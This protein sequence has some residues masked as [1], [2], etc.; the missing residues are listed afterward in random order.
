MPS[1]Q[2][3]TSRFMR[4]VV[5]VG[6][7]SVLLVVAEKP[8]SDWIVVEE[9]SKVTGLGKGTKSSGQLSETGM[10]DTLSALKG[11]FQLAQERGCTQI[12][13][14]AT[15]AARIAQNTLEFLERC[16]R[17][18]TPVQVMSGD[19]EAELGFL[20]V[21]N[22]QIFAGQ[23]LLTIIDVGGHSTEVVTASRSEN[24]WAPTFKKSFA[25]GALALRE[26]SLRLDAPPIQDILSAVSRIDD[27][28]SQRFLPSKC[29]LVVTLGATGTNL[30][31]I[32]DRIS[33]WD[34]AKVH[35]T[36]LG[37]EDVS[38]AVSSLSPLGDAGR[39]NVVGI[40][41]GR[42][43]TLH[44]GALILERCLFA[45]GANECTVSVRGWRHAML[46]DDSLWSRPS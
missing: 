34:P 8:G 2:V 10:S 21:A 13:A 15:M 33:E 1:Q 36:V 23:E 18:S 42:E 29:G 35:G 22:D 5:D 11:A 46:E 14:S 24:G 7:N 30:V 6:S 16:R 17:Q 40:E 25:I 4:A 27:V 12:L 37:Y 3:Y 9:T 41:P 45:V 39:A 28:I 44:A 19:Q 26:E 43:H 38:K 32:R 31:T 20:A